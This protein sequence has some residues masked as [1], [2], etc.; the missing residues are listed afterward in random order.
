MVAVRVAVGAVQ[1]VEGD[2]RQILGGGYRVQHDS[3]VSRHAVQKIEHHAVAAVDQERMVPC[4][5]YLLLRD[6]FD[7]REVHHHALL[8]YALGGDNVAGKRDFDGVAMAVQVAALAAVI[9]D[10]VPCIKFE[11]AC[12]LHNC[13]L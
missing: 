3:L 8:R 13:E 7:V 5:H 4:I 10:A 12:N 11:S 2:Q 6:A 9:G 1:D